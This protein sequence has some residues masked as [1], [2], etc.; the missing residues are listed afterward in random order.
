MSGRT[1]QA[2]GTERTACGTDSGILIPSHGHGALRPW[3]PGQSGNPGGVGGQLREA[4]RLARQSTLKAIQTLIAL[5]DSDDDRVRAVAANSLWD[6]AGGK[7]ME[8]NPEQETGKRIDLSKLT[9]PELQFLLKLVRSGA[10]Q[11]TE[12]SSGCT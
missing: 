4:Q 9:A 7:V 1:R 3:R 5:L 6:K 10:M 12:A 11:M 8:N 2:A